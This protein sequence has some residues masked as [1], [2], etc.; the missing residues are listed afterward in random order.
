MSCIGGNYA[1]P[2]I[3]T[4]TTLAGPVSRM[5]RLPQTGQK[6]DRST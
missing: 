4:Q 1:G 5:Q 3:G 2:E 6:K